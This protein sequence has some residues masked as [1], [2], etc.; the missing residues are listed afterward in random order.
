MSFCTVENISSE[1]KR[2]S[3]L[4]KKPS[5]KN[6]FKQLLVSLKD[7]DL[8]LTQSLSVASYRFG[9]VDDSDDEEGA[10]GGDDDSLASGWDNDKRK[11]LQ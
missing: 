9:I 6:H 8:F 1:S 3:V 11:L 7:S 2:C 10:S 4:R 5:C